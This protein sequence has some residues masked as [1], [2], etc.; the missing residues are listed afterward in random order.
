MYILWIYI[1]TYICISTHERHGSRVE[2]DV[3]VVDSN[4]M[5]AIHQMSVPP[6]F[7]I[8]GGVNVSRAQTRWARARIH[9]WVPPAALD[10]LAGQTNRGVGRWPLRFE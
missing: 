7:E 9:I 2:L 8:S 3:C 1:Y 6:T 5:R 10:G 4:R